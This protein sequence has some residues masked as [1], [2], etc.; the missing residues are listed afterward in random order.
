[1][2]QNFIYVRSSGGFFDL[3]PNRAVKVGA[4][5]EYDFSTFFFIHP[6]GYGLFGFQMPYKNWGA[7]FGTNL[8]FGISG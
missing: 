4:F 3:G 6:Y 7:F 2:T 8:G 5:S 1:M